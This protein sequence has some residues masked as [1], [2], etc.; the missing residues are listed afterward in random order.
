MPLPPALVGSV[1]LARS[2]VSPSVRLQ[3]PLS[4]LTRGWF[5][6]WG[7]PLLP[8][9]CQLE[10]ACGVEKVSGCCHSCCLRTN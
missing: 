1:F 8:D 9:P 5:R 3:L 6:F 10:A 4:W 2:S 7:S